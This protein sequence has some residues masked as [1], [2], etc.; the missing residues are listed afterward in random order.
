M[1][2]EVLGVDEVHS[3]RWLNLFNIHYRRP[4]KE[5]GF[6]GGIWSFVSRNKNPELGKLVTN[7]VV[8]V[9]T[10]NR[11]EG[12]RL[13]ISKEYRFP[14]GG[15]EWGFSAGLM[16]KNETPEAAAKRELFEETG[17]TVTKVVSVSPPIVSSA[18]LSDET[19]QMV[20]VEA[21]GELTTKNQEE[22]EDIESWLFDYD[23]I[24]RLCDR[25]G[26]FEGVIIA[27]KAW[28][29]LYMFKQLGAL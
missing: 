23:A 4:K 16:D 24:V 6:T 11:P 3:G 8:I 28:P 13:L 25:T 12:K 14:I 29:I 15:Y 26:E 9:A 2:A 1:K 22:N 19:V 20:F 10:V 18:G 17:L 5:G 7:A 21:E 27:A